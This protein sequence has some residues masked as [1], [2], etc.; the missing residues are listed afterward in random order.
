MLLRESMLVLLFSAAGVCAAAEPMTFEQALVRAQ[1]GAPSLQA[2]RLGVDAA[3]SSSVAA[4]EL[5]DPKLAIGI[6]NFP[7]SGPSAGKFGPDEMTMA[8]VGLEQDMPNGSKRSAR[9]EQAKADIQIAQAQVRG[10][11]REV[12]LGAGLAWIDLYY[13]RRALSVID[14]AQ[15]RLSPLLDTAPSGVASGRVRP[16]EAVEPELWRAQLA[17]RRSEL[18]AEAVRAKAQLVRWTGDTEADILGPPLSNDIDSNAL[19]ADLDLHPILGLANADNAR[20]D[21]QVSAA[22]AEARPDWGWDVA[23]QRRDSRWGDMVSAGVKISLPL[24]AARRQ[25]PV[26]AAR[27]IDANRARVEREASLRELVAQFEGDLADHMMHHEQ[28]TRSVETLV[29]LAQRRADFETSSYGA[30]SAILSDV[31][32]A[33]TDLADAKLIALQRETVLSRDTVRLNL[34]YGSDTP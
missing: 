8:R 3:K 32:K 26:I 23:Y 27:V 21:A 33:F 15:K 22:R 7:I 20:A 18:Q 30:G 16:G 2:K 9:Q 11:A 13:A 1:A 12:R 34:T 31:L 14:E 17:D 25:D 4:G 29:P 5:P 24:F 28:W 10:T 19:R 6:D